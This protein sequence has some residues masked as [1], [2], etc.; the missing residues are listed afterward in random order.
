V[1]H[2]KKTEQANEVL[3]LLAQTFPDRRFELTGDGLYSCRT[4]LRNMHSNVLM[5]GKLDL[6]AA[7]YGPRPL[8]CCSTR[9]WC[10]GMRST[11]MALPPTF[12]HCGP[13]TSTRSVRRSPT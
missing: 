1:P 13:G 6:E 12:S 4:V 11:A 3:D 5:V 7:L 8:R 10:S 2:V 9:S